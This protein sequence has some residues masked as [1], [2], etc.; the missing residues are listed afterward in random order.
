M[1]L[2]I[3]MVISNFFV[4]KCSYSHQISF[5][6]VIDGNLMV[7]VRECWIDEIMAAFCLKY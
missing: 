4:A 2:F 3:N 1:L 7:A 6:S 5:M